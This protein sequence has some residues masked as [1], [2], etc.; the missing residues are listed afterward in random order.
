M[1][2]ASGSR[3]S[4]SRFI[5]GVEALRPAALA[6]TLVKNAEHLRAFGTVFD[7]YFGARMAGPAPD[8]DGSEQGPGDQ[9]ESRLPP[10]VRRSL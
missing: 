8:Q 4:C 3:T 10:E 2:S 5:S 9:G 6:T 7:L 1:V